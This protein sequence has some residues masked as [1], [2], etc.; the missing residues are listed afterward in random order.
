MEGLPPRSRPIMSAPTTD[1]ERFG[2][3][4]TGLPRGSRA[5]RAMKSVELTA[6]LEDR[7]PGV[8]KRWLGQLERLQSAA[9]A[10]EWARVL[11]DFVEVVAAALPPTLGPLRDEI[12]PLWIRISEL[13]GTTA[14]WRGLAAG[15]VVE[16]VQLLRELVIRELYRDPPLGGRV[17]LSLRDV[18]RLNRSID[19]AVTHA[20]VGHTDAMF[21]QLFER[22]EAAA[23]EPGGPVNE[24]REQL[25]GIREE[26]KG[27][28]AMGAQLGGSA[29]H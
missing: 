29:E 1:T 3:F 9:G 5:R 26:L 7:M 27:L 15:E 19:R 11:E 24:V 14:A 2:P 18:L 12:E 23:H 6:W 17:P 21:F 10:Q 20:S 16:E 8:S 13:Y 25:A 4:V 22:G 28:R